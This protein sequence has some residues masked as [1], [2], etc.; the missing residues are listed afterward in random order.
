ME[1]ALL[2]SLMGSGAMLLAA[3]LNSFVKISEKMRSA[4][5]HLAAGVVFAA[6]AR[7]LVPEVI[8]QPVDLAIGFSIGVV[9][10]LLVGK[11]AGELGMLAATG[12]DLWLDGV[13]IGVAFLA[14]RETG[15]L[16]AISLAFC[17]LFLGLSVASK[18]KKSMRIWGPLLLAALLPFGT[19]CGSFFVQLFPSNYY[20]GIL[21]FG[22]AALL[23][24]VAEELLL[25]AHEVKET[26][27]ITA[28]FF[29]GFLLVLLI[30]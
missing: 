5:L 6:V 23:Y 28:S 17:A 10:M 18:I 26:P 16:V 15:I 14:G 8:G 29:A 9:A 11:W 22:V 30:K 20:V 4:T 19:A 12:I 27:W 3:L 1:T 2:Y 24:L 7:E 13:L 25:E 21:A